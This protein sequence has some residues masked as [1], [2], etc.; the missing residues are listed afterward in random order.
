LIERKGKRKTKKPIQCY[1]ENKRINAIKRNVMK[2][3]YIIFTIINGF[4][5][6]AY[7]INDIDNDIDYHLECYG[8][9]SKTYEIYD[10]KKQALQ[11]LK[12]IESKG[13]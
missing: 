7:I 10:T 6:P 9:I 13:N 2:K 3:Y 5:Y 1:L 11:R 4:D 8:D 12:E